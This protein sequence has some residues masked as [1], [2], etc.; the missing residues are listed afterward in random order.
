MESGEVKIVI[1]P[2]LSDSLRKK[3]MIRSFPPPVSPENLNPE[4]ICCTHDHP[5]HFDEATLLPLYKRCSN[6]AII[7]PGSVI[8]HCKKMGFNPART[9]TLKVGG[10]DFS[11]NGIDIKAVKAFH[12][13]DD[14]IGLAIIIGK[15]KIY[16][17]GDT[18]R[19]P[20]L[21]DSV[22]EALGGS[23]DIMMVC[24]NGKDGNMDDVDALRMVKT[25]EPRVAVPMHYGLFVNNTADPRP[26]VEAVTRIGVEGIMMEPGKKVR[27]PYEITRER[28][29]VPE[30]ELALA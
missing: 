19:Q 18:R 14:A 23:P 12:T 8:S 29:Y 13:E 17:S 24:I 20:G 15:C 5:D 30:T 22:R 16:I 11:Y 25:L 2:Y 10:K 26:F 4:I 21:E 28:G 9:F 3:G 1:D 6:C 7:G 27:F